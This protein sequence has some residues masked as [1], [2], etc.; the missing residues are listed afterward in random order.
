MKFKEWYEQVCFKFN[1]AEELFTK[2]P[3]GTLFDVYNVE[4]IEKF[5]SFK[6]T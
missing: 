2:F 6:A 1:S 4:V 5:Y 3:K